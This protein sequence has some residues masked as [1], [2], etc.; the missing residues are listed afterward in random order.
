MQTLPAAVGGVSAA[1]SDSTL[2]WIHPGDNSLLLTQFSALG[3]QTGWKR[4][5]PQPTPL[6]VTTTDRPWA[7]EP[8]AGTLL[9]MDNTLTIVEDLRVLAPNGARVTRAALAGD[10]EGR[11]YFAVDGQILA[12]EYVP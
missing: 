5:R 10:H 1:L 9:R 4:L 6:V 7:W 8:A 2:A 11:L 3:A 12:G